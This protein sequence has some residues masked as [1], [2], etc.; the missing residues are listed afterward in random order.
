MPAGS[1]AISENREG[2]GLVRFLIP[3]LAAYFLIS[4][5]LRVL[6]SSTA[7]MDETEQLIKTQVLRLGYGAQGPL[8]VW[9]QY[10]AFQIFG[11]NIFALSILKYTLLF[12]TFVC[13]LT[14]ARKTVNDSMGAALAALSLFLVPQVVWESYRTLT[15]TVLVTLLAAVTMLLIIRLRESPATLNY[16]LL[17]IT[18]GFGMLSKYNYMI[19]LLAVLTAAMTSETFRKPLLSGKIIITLTAMAAIISG[20]YIWVVTHLEQASSSSRKLKALGSGSFA[21]DAAM[22]FGT[23]VASWI[24]YIWP[25]LIMYAVLYYRFKPVRAVNPDKEIR[26]LLSRALLI[27]FAG[28]TLMILFFRVTYFKERW[29]QPLLF[30]LPVLFMCY[31]ASR[32]NRERFRA[33]TAATMVS[34]VLAMILFT[35]GVLLASTAGRSTR[36]SPPYKALAERITE[37][38]FAG[39]TIITDD[40]R[41]GGNFR[42]H[43]KDSP[44]LVTGMIR[45]PYSAEKPALV[46]WDAD[47]SELPPEE[48]TD[49]VKSLL[50]VPVDEAD[51]HYAEENYLYWEGKKM[52]LGYII[53]A[54]R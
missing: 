38:G 19:F 5:L 31:L 25:A 49:F 27:T 4:V 44:I 20:P 29:M 34:A 40:H 46:V 1:T 21:G 30:Y 7:E 24:G 2:T 43:F 14:I 36:L 26:Q 8:Y 45:V 17:G 16:L 39:G 15:H 12:S 53:I 41:I 52:K 11:V 42:L 9:L 51:V 47:R 48:L 3:V 50:K 18:A 28:C 32:L 6:V 22:G 10:L 33:F 23:L 54:P 13:I 35:G 37:D